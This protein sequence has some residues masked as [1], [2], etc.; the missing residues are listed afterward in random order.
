MNSCFF[1]H[2][3]VPIYKKFKIKVENESLVLQLCLEAFAVYSYTYLILH[4]LF[5]VHL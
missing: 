3:H 2:R 5:A 1:P 4:E